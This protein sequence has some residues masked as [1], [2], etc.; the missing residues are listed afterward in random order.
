MKIYNEIILQWNENTNK[1]DTIY[2]DSFDYFGDLV[3]FQPEDPIT[4]DN[5]TNIFSSKFVVSIFI[6][7]ISF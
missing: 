1:F 7:Q 5:T 3:L 2:E 4:P 6:S